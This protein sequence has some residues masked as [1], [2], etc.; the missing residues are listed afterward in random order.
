MNPLRPG[1]PGR[2]TGL[3][4]RRSAALV[5]VAALALSAAACGSDKGEAGPKK[6]AR[7]APTTTTVPPPAAPLTGLPDP[8]GASRRRPVLSVKVENTP[9]ARPQAGLDE[10]D[11]VWEEVVEGGI[12]RFLAMFNSRAPEVIGPVRSVRLTDPLIVW[13]VGGIFAFSGGARDSVRAIEQ[14]PVVLVDESRAGEAMFRDRAK[15]APHNLFGRAPALFAKGGEPVPPPALF[16]Y[17]PGGRGFAGEAAGGVRVGFAG[18]YAVTYTWDAASRGWTRTMGGEPFKAASGA[19]IAPANVVVLSVRYAGGAGAQGAEAQLV[20][21]GPAW[22]FSDGKVAQGRWVRPDRA[23]PAQLVDA[24]GAPI[25]L[26]PGATWVELP[27]AS[28]AV[29]VQPPGA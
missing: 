25:R 3:R 17:L 20:G 28:Y 14:A 22:V 19:T 9:A 23:R 16:G 6:R 1:G 26:V 4:L 11:V 18:S 21:E 12:T 29:E 24:A 5:A 8:S 15:R 10:A 2:P 13:P 27:D 7:P